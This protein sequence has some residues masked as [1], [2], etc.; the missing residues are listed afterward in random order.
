MKVE[1]GSKI[2]KLTDEVGKMKQGWV[3]YGE[4]YKE[5][6]SRQ[7]HAEDNASALLQAHQKLTL[8]VQ[9]LEQGLAAKDKKPI[10]EEPPAFAL[11]KKEIL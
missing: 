1:I 4:Q 2:E 9:S 6:A 10:F 7:T 5:I 8:T 3:R 11:Q